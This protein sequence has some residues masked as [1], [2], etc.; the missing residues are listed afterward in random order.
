[1]IGNQA[2][3]ASLNQTAGQLAVQ[4]RELAQQIINF[5]AYLLAQGGA[6]FVTGLGATDNDPAALV[7]AI[8]NLADWAGI[9]M[10]KPPQQALPFDYKGSTETLWGGQ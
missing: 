3:L 4:A 2:S 7:A 9:Y 5:N 8:G 1:M 6:Q 10:N